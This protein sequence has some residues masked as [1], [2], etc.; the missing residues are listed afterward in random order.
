MTDREAIFHRVQAALAGGSEADV[1]A[2]LITALVVAIGVSCESQPRAEQ[3]IDALPGEMKLALR[4][5]W[6][7][8]R[9]HRTKTILQRQL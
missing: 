8:L 9:R 2:V 1:A 6:P 3:V 7:K 5:E 4:Q